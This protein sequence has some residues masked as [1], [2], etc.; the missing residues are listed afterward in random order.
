MLGL[1]A[2]GWEARRE[3]GNWVSLELR[4]KGLRARVMTVTAPGA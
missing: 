1:K 3:G 2:W 4:T